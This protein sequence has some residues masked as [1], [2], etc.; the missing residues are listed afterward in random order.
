MT[1]PIPPQTAPLLSPPRNGRRLTPLPEATNLTV[2][3]RA[4]MAAWGIDPASARTYIRQ[5]LWVRLH[6]GVYADADVYTACRSDP[7]RLHRL[8]TR[9]AIMA[10]PVPAA[11]FGPTSGVFHYLPRQGAVPAVVTLVRDPDADRRAL[12]RRVVRPSELDAVQVHGFRLQPEDVI[13]VDGVATVTREIAAITTAA[14]GCEEW[15]V[16]VLDAV[17]WQRPEVLAEFAAQVERWSRLRGIGV[18]RRALPLVRCGAQS[19]F[20]SLSRVRL[21]AGGIPEP[22]LQVPFYDANGLIGYADMTW[23]GPRVIGECDGL[24]KYEAR[25]DVVREK[26]REDRLRALGFTVVRWTWRELM[27]DPAAVRARVRHAFGQSDRPR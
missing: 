19:P 26:L 6:R 20:E 11:A 24:V 15:A 3:R 16:A 14:S 1:T 5:G 21:V 2:F 23:D 12:R 8:M 7:E 9:A 25:A 22:R 27:S 17:A 18:V 4:D 10:L 13:R